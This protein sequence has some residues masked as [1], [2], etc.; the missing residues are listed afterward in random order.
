MHATQPDGERSGI[1]IRS[2]QVRDPWPTVG[3]NRL[4]SGSPC[5]RLRWHGAGPSARLR[6]RWPCSL[7]ALRQNGTSL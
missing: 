3:T 7:N 2:A 6:G 4:A 1:I 5:A